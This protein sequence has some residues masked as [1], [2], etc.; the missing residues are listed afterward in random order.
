MCR[1]DE[2]THKHHIIPKYM[3]G[4]DNKENLVEVTITQHAMFHYCNYQLWGNEEDRLAWRGLSG[5]ITPDE[6]ALESMILG[7]KKGGNKIKEN[8]I[9]IFALSREEKSENGKKGGKIAGQK[10]YEMK[11]G[12][13]ALTDEERS[14]NGKKSGKIS[15]ANHRDNGTG[16]FSLTKEEKIKVAQK[17]NA[18]R[19][20]C[21]V[22][23]YITSAGPLSVYQNKRGIDTSNR[24]KI[25]EPRSLEI[26]FEDGTV[27][28]TNKSLKDWAK[29]N[30][31]SY[32]CLYKVR[33]S[34]IKNHKGIIKIICL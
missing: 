16:F 22:T 27:I 30:G 20:Q 4:L 9:G 13:H 1:L 3:G 34:K 17:V 7:G 26:T 5:Q 18:Q 23:G 8:K 14:E 10:T 6:V 12:I 33:E 11:V 19:W 21:T 25:D 15:G 32:Y 31:Y 2:R 29:E 24:I 28:V